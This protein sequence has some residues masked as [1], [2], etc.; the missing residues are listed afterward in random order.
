MKHS[1]AHQT[2]RSAKKERR[3]RRS[4]KDHREAS[5]QGDASFLDGLLAQIGIQRPSDGFSGFD[6]GAP[7]PEV[8]PK[9]LPLLKRLRQPAPPGAEPIHL[10]V[11]PGVWTGFGIDMGLAWAHVTQVLLDRWGVGE[12]NLLGASLENLRQRLAD[13]PPRVERATFAGA[14][15]TVVQAVGWGS[16][17]ILLP[18]RLVDLLGETP[19]TLL[20]PVRNALIALPDDLDMDLAITIWEAF[21]DGARDE[22]ETEPMRWTGTSVT[23]LIGRPEPIH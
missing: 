6:P 16:A 21:A 12:A 19:R 3:S 18:D 4:A 14:P 20:T 1:N 8:E 11:P 17:L 5:R 22:L 9:V 7:W 15:A 10:R 13:E 2:S 23:S